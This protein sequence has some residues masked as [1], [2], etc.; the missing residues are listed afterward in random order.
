MG[1]LLQLPVEGGCS[2]CCWE[3]PGCP[4]H[5]PYRANSQENWLPHLRPG[6]HSG[7]VDGY[8]TAI[9]RSLHCWKTRNLPQR[10]KTKIIQHRDEERN[11]SS[12]SKCLVL[13]NLSLKN[14]RGVLQVRLT[15][16]PPRFRAHILLKYLLHIFHMCQFP[17][18]TEIKNEHSQ[19]SHMSLG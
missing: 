19:P 8:G 12:G 5:S 10:Y 1:C 6:V 9:L 17:R 13:Y 14:L 4:F 18:K 15:N 3:Q 2:W 11:H 7:G 16:V